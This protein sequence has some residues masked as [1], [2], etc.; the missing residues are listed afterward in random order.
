[1][2]QPLDRIEL[3]SAATDRLARVAADQEPIHRPIG[4]YEA[5]A[6]ALKYNLDASVELYQAALR[7]DELDFAHY[8]LLPKIVAEA[9]FDRRDNFLASTS[10]QVDPAT[11][12][13]VGGG[14]FGNPNTSQDKHRRNAD[15]EMSWHVLDFGLSYVRAR[16]AADEV[17][18]AEEARRKVINR[19]VED[20]RTAFWRA[21]TAERLV[22]R[23]SHLEGR[24]NAALANTRSLAAEEQASPITALTY[25]RELVE[26]KRTIRELQRELSVAKAQL[27]ALMNLKPG[28]KFSLA[29]P[30][31]PQSIPTLPAKS[32]DMIWTAMNNRPELREVAYRQRINMHE[33]DAAL[34][35]LLPGINLYA[36]ANW[37]SNSYY[38]NNDWLTWGARASWNLMRVV[39]YPARRR[40]IESQ[41]ALLD[42]R[43]LAVTMAI[44]TQV[45]V[46]Q[47]RFHHA[48]RELQTGHEYFTVQRRLVEKLRVE[49][50][51]GRISEQTLIRE[52][53]NLLVAEV[54]RD[55]A[56]ASLQNAYANV[57]AS[58][59]LDPYRDEV[60]LDSDVASLAATLRAIWIERG[61]RHGI[62]RS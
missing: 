31:G 61:R 5:M 50:A 60:D 18:I 7:R 27:A 4:L 36:G 2:P 26:I 38:L 28:T 25:E 45:H 35:E 54:K 33:A 41:G 47:I 14:A 58:M 1:M 11:G 17:L 23:L 49:Y 52:E 24:A 43:A 29:I 10:D 8:S 12:N 55:I 40:V 22:T 21:V 13:I 19:I 6:R 44:M 53:M 3:A 34:L 59:G 62:V 42:Q 39:H 9:G 16:Q 48:R 32:R 20:V 57:Y 46:S 56:H 30:S 15:I 51:A 37:D